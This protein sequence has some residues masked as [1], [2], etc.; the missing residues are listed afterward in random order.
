MK[1]PLSEPFNNVF[2]ADRP[3]K[4][5]QYAGMNP[6]D[7]APIGLVGYAIKCR[8]CDGVC[9]GASA[10]PGAFGVCSACSTAKPSDLYQ[11]ASSRCR[12]CGAILTSGLNALLGACNNCRVG[13]APLSQLPPTNQQSPPTPAKT[14]WICPVCGNGVSPSAM[15]C[16]CRQQ[17]DYREKEAANA[18]G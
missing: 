7:Y 11:S 1:N 15:V 2:D 3:Y 18:N 13:M 5:T 12:R 8:F 14:G 4:L 6:F 16:P 17:K 9:S 10:K